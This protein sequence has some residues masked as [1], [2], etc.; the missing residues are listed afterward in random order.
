MDSRV[1]E[2]VVEKI[3]EALDVDHAI[4]TA[5]EYKRLLSKFGICV[6]FSSYSILDS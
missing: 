1:V 3:C 6:L 4:I 2:R 5:R